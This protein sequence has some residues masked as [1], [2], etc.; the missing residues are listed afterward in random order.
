MGDIGTTS[1][2]YFNM[3]SS[4]PRIRGPHWVL[5]CIEELSS[6]VQSLQSIFLTLVKNQNAAQRPNSP[7]L[8]DHKEEQDSSINFPPKD[9]IYDK[10]KSIGLEFIY[11]HLCHLSTLHTTT[12]Y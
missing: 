7:I 8:D 1:F 4:A 3:F 9:I 10:D 11:K 6:I 5:Y 12:S 2:C